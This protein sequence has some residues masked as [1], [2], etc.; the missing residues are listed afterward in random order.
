MCMKHHVDVDMDMDV[1]DYKHKSLSL[2]LVGGRGEWW[3]EGER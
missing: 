2:W 1:D 3:V